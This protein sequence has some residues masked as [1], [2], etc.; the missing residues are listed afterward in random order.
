MNLTENQ[1][2]RLRFLLFAKAAE[3]M[4]QRVHQLKQ[5]PTKENQ[6]RIEAIRAEWVIEE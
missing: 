5:D 6:Q 3:S 4:G 1:L 2:Q